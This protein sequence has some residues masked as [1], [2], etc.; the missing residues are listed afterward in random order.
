MTTKSPHALAS[1]EMAEAA[2][3][4]LAGLSDDLRTKATYPYMD[5]ER[6]FWYYPPINR[7][8]VFFG[9]RDLG[10]VDTE[11]SPDS[12]QWYVI[13]LEPGV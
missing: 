12:A 13:K 8:G 6:I 10:Y 4:F 2:S 7:H 11:Y 5:A 1:T 3:A 9:L